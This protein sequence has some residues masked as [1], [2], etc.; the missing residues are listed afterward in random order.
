MRFLSNKQLLSFALDVDVTD[1]KHQHL[2]LLLSRLIDIQPA[3]RRVVDG[4]PT[5]P[6]EGYDVDT[7]SCVSCH[8]AALSKPVP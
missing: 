1:V 2:V 7:A 4:G 6:C 5:F 8:L 3:G